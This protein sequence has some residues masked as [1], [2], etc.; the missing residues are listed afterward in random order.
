MGRLFPTQR[1]FTQV[2]CLTSFT[3]YHPRVIAS[4]SRVNM[5][6]PTIKNREENFTGIQKLFRNLKVFD[7]VNNNT[8]MKLVF[9][10]MTRC[11]ARSVSFFSVSL[12]KKGHTEQQRLNFTPFFIGLGSGHIYRFPRLPHSLLPREEI[13][14]GYEGGRRVNPNLSQSY[15]KK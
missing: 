6:L 11:T 4:G 7:Y 15:I 5:L 10:L 8:M 13:L 1:K 14:Q 2:A 3:F 12:Y 9:V